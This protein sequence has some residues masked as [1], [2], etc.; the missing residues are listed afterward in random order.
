MDIQNVFIFTSCK[1]KMINH[2]F[3]NEQI[4]IQNVFIYRSIKYRYSLNKFK[5]A[6][7]KPSL[8]LFN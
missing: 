4:D 6:G 7:L 5:F 8:K 2:N 1:T 3:Y